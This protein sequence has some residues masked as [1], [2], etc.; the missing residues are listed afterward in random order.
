MMVSVVLLMAI[1]EKSDRQ[2]IIIMN[3]FQEIRFFGKHFKNNDF[4]F[5][6]GISDE[7]REEL[8]KIFVDYLKNHNERKTQTI[9][10]DLCCDVIR[11]KYIMFTFNIYYE[12]F[13]IEKMA[14]FQDLTMKA[15]SL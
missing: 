6:F 4:G 11:A 7:V 15:I 3:K 8:F 10:T 2:F 14:S 9:L 13:Y 12:L 1:I 5:P